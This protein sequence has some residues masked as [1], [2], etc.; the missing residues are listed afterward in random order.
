MANGNP[1]QEVR[2]F[3]FNVLT[4]YIKDLSFESPNAPWSLEPQSERPQI[5]LQINVAAARLEGRENDYE[6]TLNIQGKAEKTDQLFFR[7]AL[8]YGGVFR[9]LNV[10]QE[11]LHPLIMIECPRILFPFA[12][13]V[14]ASCV[15][16]AGFPQLALDP[17]DFVALY[18]RNQQMQKS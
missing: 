8:V 4:Q 14:V 2:L 3:Q 16:G 6:V 11:N 17:V 10:P 13:E 7:F 12:R 9:L 5:N 15:R 1:S 18:Q